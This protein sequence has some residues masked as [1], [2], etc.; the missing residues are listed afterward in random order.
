MATYEQLQSLIS[1]I[2]EKLKAELHSVEKNILK[3]IS[4]SLHICAAK[5]D[6]V[7]KAR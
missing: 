3:S 1:N 5:I 6:A 2:E 4:A 7:E